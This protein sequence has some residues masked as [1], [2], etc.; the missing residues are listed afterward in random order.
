V[1]SISTTQKPNQGN[2][3]YYPPSR[4]TIERRKLDGTKREVVISTGI[5]NCEGL[6]IDWMG[7]NIYWTDDA[8]MM[9]KVAKLDNVNMTKTLIY[10]NLHHPR[11]IVVDPKKG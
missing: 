6:A 4:F 8:L 11:D 5:N 3:K 2:R 7:R 9:I 10:G 1:N